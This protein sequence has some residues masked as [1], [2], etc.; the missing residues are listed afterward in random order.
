M[1]R[2]RWY[3]VLLFVG[4][5]LFVGSCTEEPLEVKNV[6]DALKSDVLSL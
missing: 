5:L 3:L 6:A 1:K 4:I 2:A